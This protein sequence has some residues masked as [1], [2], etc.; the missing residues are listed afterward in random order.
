MT[1]PTETQEPARRRGRG[2]RQRIL[3]A[4]SELFYFEGINAT[5]VGRIASKKS[6]S[7]RT[8]YQHFPS[9]T[10]LV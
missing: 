9:K 4:A 7:K 10:A 6:V 3:N 8:L 5:G 1:S 2:A